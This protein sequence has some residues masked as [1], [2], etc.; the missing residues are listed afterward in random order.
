MFCLITLVSKVLH[1]HLK[2]HD[3]SGIDTLIG[4][5]RKQIVSQSTPISARAML[6]EIYELVLTDWK[7]VNETAKHFYESLSKPIMKPHVFLWTMPTNN[8]KRLQKEFST[9]Q[10]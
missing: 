1:T 6:L 9:I 2:A 10:S 4:K 3:P 8:Y 5:M 7:S